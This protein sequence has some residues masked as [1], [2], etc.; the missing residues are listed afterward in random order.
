MS[1]ADDLAAF[2]AKALTRMDDVFGRS[3]ELLGEELART[4]P[5]G[6]R[7][8]FMTGNLARS[9]MAD[10][11]KMPSMADGPF[12]G[13]NIGLVSATL[14]AHETVWIGYQARYARRME[15]GFVGADSLGRVYNQ[16][17]HH[18]VAGAAAEWRRIV[19]QAVKEVVGT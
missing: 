12:I 2:R 18:F 11:T 16:P 8:P 7:V 10:K 19:A 4:K 3:V 6:G 1:F 17:G 5:Q 13:S 14:K 9:L 15:H